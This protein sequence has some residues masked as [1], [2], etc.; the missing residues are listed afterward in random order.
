MPHSKTLRRGQ[1][2]AHTPNGQHGR[3]PGRHRRACCLARLGHRVAYA[4]VCG[5]DEPDQRAAPWLKDFG[6]EP[7]GLMVK[8]G[9][10]SQQA[11]MWRSRAANTPSSSTATRPVIPATWCTPCCWT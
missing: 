10:R 3:W 5:D 7:H 6:V 2:T 8:P 9:S 1:Q 4:G 11:F